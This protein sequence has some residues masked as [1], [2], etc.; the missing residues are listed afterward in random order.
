MFEDNSRDVFSLKVERS[1]APEQV[2]ARFGVAGRVLKTILL[3]RRNDPT[4]SIFKILI[5][6]QTTQ[7]EWQQALH[8]YKDNDEFLALYKH[9]IGRLPP[10]RPKKDVESVKIPGPISTTL[11]AVFAK[12]FELVAPLAPQER[13]RL[14]DAAHKLLGE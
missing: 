5:K 9:V 2:Y 4:I 7:K 6:A 12:V 11:P 14:F 1:N 10:L 3:E 8:K 13:R